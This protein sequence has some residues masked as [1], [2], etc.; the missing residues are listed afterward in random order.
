MLLGVVWTVIPERDIGRPLGVLLVLTATGT[1]LVWGFHL[2]DR[3]SRAASRVPSATPA[4]RH[5]VA[6][7]SASITASHQGVHC[8]DCHAAFRVEIQPSPSG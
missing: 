1:L 8:H 2:S 6:C 7:G 5:C 4:A 3:A